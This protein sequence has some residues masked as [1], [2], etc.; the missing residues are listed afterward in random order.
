MY[1]EANIAIDKKVKVK[2]LLSY[3]QY[4]HMGSLAY[5]LSPSQKPKTEC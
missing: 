4:F 2:F 5:P 1:A 3:I